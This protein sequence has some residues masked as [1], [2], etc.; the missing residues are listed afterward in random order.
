M[1]Y[2]SCIATNFPN[3]VVICRGDVN[4]YN[5][6]EWV[7]GDPLPSEQQL[8]EAYISNFKLEKIASLS[9]ECEEQIIA[10]FESSAL[11]SP[12]YYDSEIVDQMNLIGAVSTIAPMTNMPDGFVIEYA[13]RPVVN[14]IKQSKLYINHTYAQLRAVMYDG[15]VFKLTKL[16]NFNNIRNYINNNEL[17][18]EEIELISI[19]TVIS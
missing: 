7:S 5:N 12:H 3:T 18:I 1:N 4:A 14:T 10:G 13:C 6:I 11:G 2:I 16:Q 15:A 8:I 19:H 9:L 17:T